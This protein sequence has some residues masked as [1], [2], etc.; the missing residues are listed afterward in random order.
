[1]ARIRGRLPGRA[2]RG[3]MRFRS[4]AAVLVVVLGGLSFLFTGATALATPVAASA[5]VSSTSLC[6]TTITTSTTL[7][8]DVG[9]CPGNG[10]SFGAS[11]ITLNCNGYAITGTGSAG[12]IGILS[13]THDHLTVENCRVT[14]FAG[15]VLLQKE[16]NAYDPHVG[17]NTLTNNS[18]SANVDNG[19][20]IFGEHNTLTSNSAKGNTIDSGFLLLGESP[21]LFFL[22]ANTLINNS[23]V[24]N[25]NRGF[26][27]LGDDNSLTGN[28]AKGNGG[29]GF[30]LGQPFGTPRANPSRFNDLE[31]NTAVKNNAR[32]FLVFGPSNTFQ[33]DNAIGNSAEGF[34]PVGGVETLINSVANGNGGNG[35]DLQAGNSDALSNDIAVHNGFNGFSVQVTASSLVDSSANNNAQ[36]GFMDATSGSGTSGTSNTYLNDTC[37]GNGSGDSN[38]AQL[39][40]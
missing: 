11:G 33:G 23:A 12:S 29:S 20:A 25:G 10:I 3:I 13:L 15:G 8:A 17:F 7:T 35:F 37:T 36:F 28:S 27:V 1:M 6:G 16:A 9:P 5:L 38:P 40:S 30:L 18:A 26:F 39:C 21:R 19:F 22:G 4:W 31:D 24:D 32:G 14:D 34:L 2:E